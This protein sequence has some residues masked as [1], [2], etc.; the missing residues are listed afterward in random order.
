MTEKKQAAEVLEPTASRESEDRDESQP[1]A[2]TGDLDTNE[3]AVRE[4]ARRQLS[5]SVR[6]LLLGMV[7]AGL[8]TAVGAL[9]WLY[10]GADR[11][12][13]GQTHPSQ[14]TAH[15]EKVALDYATNAAAMSF[16]DLTGW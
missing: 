16:E 6:D 10:V 7:I 8:V 9:A 3:P 4:R 15:A 5:F 1:A 14:N 12:L 11:E 13:D 2:E